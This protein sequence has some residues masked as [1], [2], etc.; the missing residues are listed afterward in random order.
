VVGSPAG[1]GTS[2]A[3]AIA[4]SGARPTFRFL[5][6]QESRFDCCS[7]RFLAAAAACKVGD[8]AVGPGCCVVPGGSGDVAGVEFRVAEVESCE[9]GGRELLPGEVEAGDGRGEVV[10]GWQV[11][12]SHFWD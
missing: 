4:R 5:L 7:R 6:S 9:V 2:R 11:V 1:S 8:V 10:V 12:I 3:L